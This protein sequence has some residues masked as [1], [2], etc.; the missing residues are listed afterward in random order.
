MKTL[1]AFSANHNGRQ[2]GLTND[3]RARRIHSK[4]RFEVN[5]N[6]QHIFHYIFWHN[7]F[8]WFDKMIWLCIHVTYPL[9]II[10]A[11]TSCIWLLWFFDC[12]SF[13]ITQIIWKTSRFSLNDYFNSPTL[14]S[15]RNSLSGVESFGIKLGCVVRMVVDSILLRAEF[16]PNDHRKDAPRLLGHR[17]WF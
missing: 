4:T 1:L 6:S 15:H 3:R 14:W 11:H 2:I 5:V 7:S 17:S 9:T 8:K 13:L 16:R 10:F 12:A